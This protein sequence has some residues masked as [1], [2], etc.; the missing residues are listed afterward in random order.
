[1]VA[2]VLDTTTF[3]PDQQNRAIHHRC[4]ATDLEAEDP[5][6]VCPLFFPLCMHY[7]NLDDRFSEIGSSVHFLLM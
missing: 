2:Q 7:N 4:P 1:M 3:F 5:Y 6:S